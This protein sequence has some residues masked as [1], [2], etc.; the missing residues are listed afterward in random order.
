MINENEESTLVAVETDT[1]ILDDSDNSAENKL[2]IE[3]SAET[4]FK[5]I[6]RQYNL[7]MDAHDTLKD[8]ANGI[9]VGNGTIITLVTLAT[10]QLLNTGFV[11]KIHS[12]ILLVFIP[13]TFL[14]FSMIFAIKSY[15]IVG[16][17]TI[18]ATELLNKYYRNR[19]VK[20][21]DQLSS[22]VALYV[23]QNKEKSKERR[24]FVNLAMVFLL[25]GLFSFAVILF[26]M[27]IFVLVPIPEVNLN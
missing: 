23:D 7:E 1:E 17:T 19:K 12:L 3:K 15:L 27:F 6:I 21:L 25:V 24:K 5:E 8:K 22:N 10:I 2:E 14:I 20:I 11:D 13:Y 9:M 26:I 4:I 16:L 18:N